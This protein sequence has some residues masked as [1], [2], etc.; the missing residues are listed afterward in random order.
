VGLDVETIPKGAACGT[1]HCAYTAD[2]WLKFQAEGDIS[3]TSRVTTAGPRLGLTSAELRIW[4]RIAWYP[5]AKITCTTSRNFHAAGWLRENE[6]PHD[7][8]NVRHQEV[9]GDLME[10]EE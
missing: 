5:P 2:R 7:V 1:G 3:F 6:G 9:S 10:R 8:E 4:G